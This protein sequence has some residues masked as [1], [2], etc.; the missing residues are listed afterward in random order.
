MT[1][2]NVHS[3]MQQ[4]LQTA[5]AGKVDVEYAWLQDRMTLKCH[6]CGAVYR[7]GTPSSPDR[8][9]WELQGW[10]NQHSTMGVHGKEEKGSPLAPIPLTADFKHPASWDAIPVKH[11]IPT[12]PFGNIDESAAKAELIKAQME[13]YKAE[14]ES[15][16]LDKKIEWLKATEVQ[17]A[18]IKAA[19][20]QND[21]AAKEAALLKLLGIMSKMS[22]AVIPAPVAPEPP[23][24]TVRI[25]T[26]R[27]FR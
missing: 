25:V 26:G 24:K 5:T 1:S 16:S 10:V 17:K 12:K 4:W 11:P 9:D 21:L 19:E 15:K 2:T 14:Q 8:I 22:K 13:K 18:A 7:C 3:F 6:Q 20:E 27:R 23:T